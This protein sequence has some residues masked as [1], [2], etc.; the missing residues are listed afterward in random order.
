MQPIIIGGCVKCGTSV[1]ASVLC[2]GN[3][4]NLMIGEVIH[5]NEIVTNYR[6]ARDGVA[7]T[8]VSQ[9]EG[10][11]VSANARSCQPAVPG[12]VL[13][14]L[15]DLFEIRLPGRNLAAAIERLERFRGIDFTGVGTYYAPSKAR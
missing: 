11:P 4:V 1:L 9:R 6:D 2:S 3:D 12:T 13:L 8:V 7:S 5:L 10:A 15:Y 14:R